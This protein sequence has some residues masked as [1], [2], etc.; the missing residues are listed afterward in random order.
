MI[1]GLIPL[2]K[3]NQR[4]QN[5]LEASQKKQVKVRESS[6]TMLDSRS[7]KFYHLS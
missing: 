1:K 4:A 7:D 2:T 5:W 6:L 3:V